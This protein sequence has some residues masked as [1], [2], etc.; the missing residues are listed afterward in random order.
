MIRPRYL[1]KG[2]TVGITAPAGCLTGKEID[3]A[4]E[5]IRSWG[6]NVV[7][8][9]HLLSKHHSFA[10]TD[11]HRAEDLQQMLD[12]RSINAIICARGGYGT[13]RIINKIKFG[14]FLKHPKWIAGYS[15]VTV[16]H[17]ALQQCLGVESI[18]GAMPRVVPPELPDVVSL[19]SLRAMLFGEISEYNVELAAELK[20]HFI[21]AGHYRTER[22][23]IQ[24]LTEKIK[25]DLKLEARFF[26]LPHPY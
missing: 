25:S 17:G 16:L 12:D 20:C 18:H 24:A 2:D 8:G 4:V 22:F 9:K 1:R 11:N 6:L 26:D 23:G 14:H 21:A 3:P 7:F 13:I 15:D 19:D 5:M 10:G